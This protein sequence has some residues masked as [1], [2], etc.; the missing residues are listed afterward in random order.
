MAGLISYKRTIKGFVSNV[1]AMPHSA[2]PPSPF[3]NFTITLCGNHPVR[4]T[5]LICLDSAEREG[6]Y[7]YI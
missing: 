4:K 7:I 1:A 6:Y 2:E 5:S 3:F